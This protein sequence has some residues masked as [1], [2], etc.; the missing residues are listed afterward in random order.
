MPLIDGGTV[1]LPRAIGMSRAMDMILTGRPVAAEEALHIGLANRLVAKDELMQ[2]AET[3]A[4]QIAAFPQACLRGDRQS[5]L[6]QEALP[7]SAA[8]RNEF[9][10]GM[11]TLQS[12]ETLSGASGFTQG[13]GRH[14]RFD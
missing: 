12:G 4:R 10:H 5:A 11:N 13:G 14:G 2:A 9:R 6:E 8:L 3:L 7:E 1:R